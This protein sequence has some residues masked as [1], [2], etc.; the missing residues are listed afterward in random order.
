MDAKQ[1]AEEAKRLKKAAEKAERA[2][3]K[4]MLE[5][6][7]KFYEVI[8]DEGGELTPPPEQPKNDKPDSPR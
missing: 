6:F 1:F 7:S 3:K 5:G 4:K 8:A 2:S